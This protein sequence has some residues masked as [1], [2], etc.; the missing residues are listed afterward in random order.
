MSLRRAGAIS[1]T[2]FCPLGQHS[3]W[4]MGDDQTMFIESPGIYKSL[5]RELL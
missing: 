4:N 3:G 5:E 2:S 1:Y